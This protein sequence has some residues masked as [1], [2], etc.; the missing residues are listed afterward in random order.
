MLAGGEP[1]TFRAPPASACQRKTPQPEADSAIESASRTVFQPT[2]AQQD[3]CTDA[4]GFAGREGRSRGIVLFGSTHP[5]DLRHPESM[6]IQTRCSGDQPRNAPGDNAIGTTERA[7]VSSSPWA[8]AASSGAG[9][10][11]RPL[12]NRSGGQGGNHLGKLPGPAQSLFADQISGGQGM[13]PRQSLQR[14]ALHTPTTLVEP[15]SSACPTRNAPASTGSSGPESAPRSTPPPS[16][17]EE[18]LAPR[19]ADSAAVTGQFRKFVQVAMGLAERHPRGLCGV[20]NPGQTQQRR[21]QVAR[22]AGVH[23]RS[24]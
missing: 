5:I 14:G 17:T 9:T 7:R 20:G 6:R 11:L 23:E 3:P 22:A 8:T 10:E 18:D 13:Q 19:T 4:L 1:N 16:S 21:E 2:A 24:R 15:P 12:T